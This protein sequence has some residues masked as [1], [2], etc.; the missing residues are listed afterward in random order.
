MKT[1]AE[2]LQHARDLKGWSQAQLAAASG[3]SQST[4]GNIEAGTRKAKGSLP[5]IAKALG[6]SHDWLANGIGDMKGEAAPPSIPYS[7]PSNLGRELALVFDMIPETD[8]L[9]RS[10][11]YSLAVGAIAAVLQGEDITQ[12]ITPNPKK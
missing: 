8:T 6:I 10:K 3:L 2:R 1:V 11:A 7:E 12:V 4:I 5:E 9:K